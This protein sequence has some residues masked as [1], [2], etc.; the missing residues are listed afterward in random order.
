M[1]LAM[2]LVLVWEV[3]MRYGFN[4]PTCWAHETSQYFFGA[5]F[6]IGGA[7][8]LRWGS[9]VSVDVL[10][11]RLSPR[12]AALL[13]LFT[14][15]LFYIFCGFLL[16]R[17]WEAAWTSVTRWENTYSPWGPPLW[18]LRLTIPLAAVLVLLQ[19]LT[20]TINDVYTAITG[21][22]LIVEVIEK[23]EL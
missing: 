15:L 6:I 4:A 1:I 21:H 19:G 12:A 22:K 13:D 14:W 8:A 20:K 11:G 9:H 10:Y 3:L 7:Y 23:G 16:G 18:P 17:G 2:M 5:H